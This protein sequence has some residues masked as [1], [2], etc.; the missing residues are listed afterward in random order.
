[1][2]LPLLII[3]AVV[4]TASAVGAS[5]YATY[6]YFTDDEPKKEPENK[7]INLGRFAIWGHADVGKTTFI[8][9]LREVPLSNKKS[10]TTSRRAFED[11]PEKIVNGNRYKIEKIVD[12]PGVFDRFDDWL[13]IAVE[14]ESISYLVDLS[15]WDNHEDSDS[16]V[17]G[18]GV[19]IE[20]TV[21][22]L[23]VFKD[24]K[25]R[26]NIIFTH[27]D[28]S[29]WA[30][31]ETARVVNTLHKVSS[32]RKLYE[33]MNNSAVAGYIYSVNLI[34]KESFS[35]LISDIISDSDV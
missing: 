31:V 17:I 32:I 14:Y 9:Q 28:K 15:R 27:L 30:D 13:K 6:K 1:M 20:K 34:N 26:L 11:I 4:A 12:M 3:A 35:T 18:V 5:G 8:Q 22:A 7:V 16:Y 23:S 19:D 33:G 2:P 10:Q 21:S 29:K 24:T 25:R